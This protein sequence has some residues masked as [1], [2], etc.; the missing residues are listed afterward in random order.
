MDSQHIATIQKLAK[1]KLIKLPQL[2][3]LIM[4]N[5]RMEGWNITDVIRV[6]GCPAPTVTMAKNQL[7]K[8][9]LLFEQFPERDRRLTKVYLTDKGRTEATEMWYTLGSLVAA[10]SAIR[11]AGSIA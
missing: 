10:E 5:K 7:I 1:S 3:L 4:A 8:Q 6:T 2:I 9:E 11:A